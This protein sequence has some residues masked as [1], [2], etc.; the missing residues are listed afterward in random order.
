MLIPSFALTVFLCGITWIG[1]NRALPPPP[2]GGPIYYAMAPG[3][4]GSIQPRY[5]LTAWQAF[6]SKRHIEAYFDDRCLPVMAV[7]FNGRKAAW[8]RTWLWNRD[9]RLRR[10]L[11]L[12]AWGRLVLIETMEYD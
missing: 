4:V 10:R 8:R 3:D 7:Y 2:V 11:T 12:D 9:G 5:R 1:V 6:H